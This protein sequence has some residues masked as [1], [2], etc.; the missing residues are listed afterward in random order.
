M[1][2]HSRNRWPHRQNTWR[3]AGATFQWRRATLVQQYGNQ[4]NFPANGWCNVQRP[5]TVFGHSFVA[6]AQKRQR[7]FST[8]NFDEPSRAQRQSSVNCIHGDEAICLFAV[9]VR[10]AFAS[11]RVDAVPLPD[12]TVNDRDWLSPVHPRHESKECWPMVCFTF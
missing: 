2:L 4:Y 1:A 6:Q 9:A 11:E 12:A 8:R 3:P 7:T 10:R 5:S